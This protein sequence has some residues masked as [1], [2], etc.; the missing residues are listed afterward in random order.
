MV[1]VTVKF[2]DQSP[3]GQSLN[4]SEDFLPL[5]ASALSSGIALFGESGAQPD[6]F[7]Y[8]IGD[9]NQDT[10]IDLLEK[11]TVR[12][13]DDGSSS[14]F[15]TLKAKT[16]TETTQLKY[17]NDHLPDFYIVVQTSLKI[18]QGDRFEV[19]IPANGI[20]IEDMYE[21]LVDDKLYDDVFPGGAFYD[22][23]PDFAE[24]A[25]FEG[26][27]V[28]IVSTYKD[29]DNTN[30]IGASSEPT[31]V[32]GLDLVGREDVEYFVEEI[33]VN[34]IGLNLGA[35]SRLI[36]NLSQ[37]DYLGGQLAGMDA[38]APGPSPLEQLNWYPTFF[39][40]PW[41]YNFPTNAETGEWLLE[42]RLTADGEEYQFPMTMPLD[43]YGFPRYNFYLGSD[44]VSTNIMN[45]HGFPAREAFA[46]SRNP[47]VIAWDIFKDFNPNKAG[48]V[49][50]YR[51]LGGTQG[52]YDPDVDHLIKL[53]LKKFRIEPYTIS[54]DEVQSATS[55]LRPILR[56]LVPGVIG[57]SGAKEIGLF[58]FGDDNLA[59]SL[60]GVTAL[61]DPVP[62]GR[63]PMGSLDCYMDPDC[64]FFD[65]MINVLRP[66]L[67]LTEGQIRYLFE[68]TEA[69]GRTN[70]YELFNDEM[71]KGFTFVMPVA[72]ENALSDLKVPAA[73]TG[74]DAGPDIYI[75]V[76]T[77]DKLRALDSF[78][79]FIQPNDIKIGTNVTNFTKNDPTNVN[80]LKSV[81]SIGVGRANTGTTYSL[82]GRPKPRFQFQDLTQPGEGIDASNNNI[83]YDG[84]MSSPPKA[85]IGIDVT[86]F[87]Q[88]ANLVINYQSIDGYLFDTFMTENTVLGDMHIDFLP[89]PNSLVLNPAIL[90][91]LPYQVGVDLPFSSIISDHS[92]AIYM[93]DD[94]PPGDG[95]DTDGDGL[96]DEEL[97]NLIDDDSDGLIDEDLG[98]NTPAGINGVHDPE[99]RFLPRYTDNGGLTQDFGMSYVFP[100]ND[101]TKFQ[102][103]IDE[104]QPEDDPLTITDEGLIPLDIT[105][106]SWFA[107]LDFR[108]LSY[109]NYTMNRGL[110]FSSGSI[111][112]D[113]TAGPPYA[114]PIYNQGIP[115]N[116]ETFTGMIEFLTAIRARGGPFETFPYYPDDLFVEDPE[117]G[118]II[119]LLTLVSNADTDI[120][121]RADPDG[122]PPRSW[123]LSFAA[124]LRIPNPSRGFARIGMVPLVTGVTG[125]N[126]NAQD[127]QGDNIVEGGINQ[128][129]LMISVAEAQQ[130]NEYVN[131]VV[132]TLESAYETAYTTKEDFE[133]AVE[134]A[135]AAADE[136]NAEL[137]PGDEEV[138][139]EFPDL[140]EPQEVSVTRP[141]STL[142]IDSFLETNNGQYDT[143]YQYQI[144]LPDENLGPLR[145]N[146]FFV[147]LRAADEA[148]VGESFRVR[149]RSGERN[150]FITTIDDQD[151]TVTTI[152]APEGGIGYQSFIETSYRE[153]FR[154]VSKAQITTEE[155]V[156]R[157]QNVAPSLRFISPGP[158][159]NLASDE[160]EFVVTFTASDPDNVAQIQLYVDDDS[161]GFNGTFIPGALLREGF[162][163]QFTLDMTT[164]PNFD[165]LKKYYVY[166][167]I[168]DNVNPAGY[169]YAGG[170]I[171]TPASVSED[172]GGGDSIV[173]V[174]DLANPLDYMKITQDGRTFSLGNAPSFAQ[175]SSVT[176]VVDMELT[177]TVSGEILLLANGN[178]VGNGD[179]G[180][181][182][183]YMQPN[184]ELSFSDAET[185]F[186]NSATGDLITGPTDQI[187]IES[188]RDVEV[189][190]EAGAIYILDGDGDMLFLGK[191]NTNL[192]PEG[193][194]MDL[195]RDMELSPDGN[196]MYFL[197]GNGILSTAGP[198]PIGAWS[199]LIAEDKYRDMSLIV[200]GVAVSNIVITD[201]D[202][203]LT[204]LG[205]NNS[206]KSALSQLTIPED[207]EP[208]TVRQIKTFPDNKSILLLV[209]GSGKATVLHPES[210]ELEIPSDGFVFADS[211]GLDDDQI[212]DVETTSI[213]IQSVV[214]AVNDILKGFENENVAQIMAYVSPDYEDQTGADAKALRES[215]E[216]FFAFYEVESYSISRANTDSFTITTQGDIANAQVLIDISVLYPRMEY[217]IPEAEES[218][219]SIVLEKMGQFLFQGSYV[220]FD[221]TIRIREVSDG[222]AW[223]IQLWE[224][225]N[226]GRQTQDLID[227]QEVTEYDDLNFLMTQSEADLI[228]YY[229]PKS[230]S[231][232]SPIYVSIDVNEN[233]PLQ[234]YNI[235]AVMEELFYRRDYAPPAF[236]F[237]T[238][239]GSFMASVAFDQS[240]F[241]FQRMGDG[242]YKLISMNFRQL[243]S[244]NDQDFGLGDTGGQQ[245]SPLSTL[246]GLEVENPFGFNFTDRGPVLAAF[247]GDADLVYAADGLEVT[248]TR[249]AI[250]MLP[251][252]TDIFSINPST[253]FNTITRAVV[254]TNPYDPANQGGAAGGQTGFSASI[255]D[256]GGRAY[257]IIARDG[258]HYGFIQIPTFDGA[259]DPTQLDPPMIYFDFRFEDSFI[260]P[261][262]F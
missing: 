247:S 185:V 207:I 83:L 177:P 97:Y 56:R 199:D 140:P 54:P 36:A 113:P 210:A 81:S 226:F 62:E 13:A 254:R 257:F 211:P 245:E 182:L 86:D 19:S 82:I 93:D 68:Y 230:E 200:D 181:F 115:Y 52:K 183:N 131:T 17:F 134:E 87:G 138:E 175:V 205:S 217:I 90:G 203:K 196:H 9:S 253:F 179:T 184:G 202:G 114:D 218:S 101:Q 16:G 78:I 42:T 74:D 99:D 5:A 30:R 136:A 126:A 228:S 34:W 193:L 239:T 246:D 45:F 91:V 167:R 98:D 53:D 85:V 3:E 20:Q 158:G 119:W 197:S 92:I 43:W 215:L 143:N 150:A 237:T 242:S 153:E 44:N 35:V 258:K 156:V 2:E 133:T 108:A 149:I 71:I 234:P 173:V 186:Y 69:N 206:V 255:P 262:G 1:Q 194:G 130:I 25:V 57:G 260:L 48:G 231:A 212:V 142:G 64:L 39:Y 117:T 187:S 100:P 192:R 22:L 106:G 188:A 219:T 84:S 157:S 221:Q 208:G 152:D 225:R 61:P 29:V 111:P 55:P 49:F 238:Y 169:F 24:R 189:D 27:I 224:L 166:G 191:A 172:E 170:A 26:D 216:T 31:S 40:S 235:L 11:P 240:T 204:I 21:P 46:E 124:G 155:I 256:G 147:V 252:G 233:D 178:V 213:N 79:P 223:R 171:Q 63:P 125:D 201:D 72:R 195:Y 120:P 110:I 41:F 73:R 60:M 59:T 28:Q 104:I 65:L 18:L 146:D 102:D 137:E 112:F 37:G 148:R 160:L 15:V 10:P 89:G 70:S 38:A 96:I 259:S 51:E 14:F 244:Q 128:F 109:D 23:N 107:S 67:G 154:N 77:S 139:P 198:A 47:K 249:G 241:K 75:S 122:D 161:L 214:K 190:F 121:P 127:P 94:T 151:G 236:E 180:I 66:Y 168:D 95:R 116:I 176:R 163:T 80:S 58:L 251:E 132:D 32:L 165:P 50:A 248:S 159:L 76:Q 144:Q 162:D 129:G 209:Q 232:E 7:N 164:I 174:D 33:R 4:I 261:S 141:A 88:N 103:F 105:E 118:D 250:M 8:A 12:A 6:G 222:R 123:A 227:Q 243:I 220:P 145:G 229:Q 135:I